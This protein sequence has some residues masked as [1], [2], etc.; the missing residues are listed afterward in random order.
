MDCIQSL[1]SKGYKI[2]A[3]S[4]HAG[5][6]DIHELDLHHPLAIVMG[7]ENV[8]ISD[9]VKAEADVFVKIPMHGFTESLNISV[10]AAILLQDISS[11]LRSY[12]NC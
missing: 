7:Q 3:T 6:I 5:S 12:R 4:P 10:A 11:R 9:V 2:V 1:K 8:G